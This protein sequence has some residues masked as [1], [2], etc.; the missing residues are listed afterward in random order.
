MS[1]STTIPIAPDEQ[2]ALLP[3]ERAQPSPDPWVKIIPTDVNV[4]MS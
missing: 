1:E 4:K 2:R 3:I